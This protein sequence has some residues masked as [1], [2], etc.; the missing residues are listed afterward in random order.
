VTLRLAGLLLVAVLALVPVTVLPTPPVTWL[1]GLA[2]VVGGVGALTLTTPLVTTGASLAVIG[3]ALALALDRP[4]VDPVVAIAFGAT[5]VLVLPLAHF[6]ERAHGA[7]VPPAVVAAQV[8]GWLAL[9]LLGAGIAAAL[10][11]GAGLLTPVLA[12]A[13]LPVVVAVAGLGASLA[14]AALVRALLER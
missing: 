4:A 7:M 8:R 2:L 6:A 3:Y 9:A 12:G 11:A 13:R 5:L 10:T 1:A 14:V